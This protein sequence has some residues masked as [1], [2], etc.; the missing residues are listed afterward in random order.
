MASVNPPRAP[1]LLYIGGLEMEHNPLM[2]SV[3]AADYL[4][5]RPQ[6]LAKWRMQDGKHTI[7]FVKIG[8]AV[9][10]QRSELNKYIAAHTFSNTVEA[11]HILTGSS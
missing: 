7:P 3:E 2:T 1:R 11:F 6:T 4:S 10:Y 5:V 9:R 8:K